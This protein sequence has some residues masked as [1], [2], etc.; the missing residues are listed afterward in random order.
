MGVVVVG[1]PVD[2]VVKIVVVPS[3][4]VVGPSV[5]VVSGTVVVVSG[6]VVVVVASGTVVVVVGD[7]VGPV[8][9]NRV[10]DRAGHSTEDRAG[11]VSRGAFGDRRGVTGDGVRR[12]ADVRVD[13]GDRHQQ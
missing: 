8:H 6:T 10:R 1:P 4:V 3:T 11:A 9:V 7:A 2:V 13:R 12:R 5:V